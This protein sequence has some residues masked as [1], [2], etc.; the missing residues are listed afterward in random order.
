MT[1]LLLLLNIWNLVRPEMKTGD[2][3]KGGGRKY[4]F[5]QLRWD[6]RKVS[7]KS[8]PGHELWR[9]LQMINFKV[10]T[11]GF[12]C[13]VLGWKW[14]L[15]FPVPWTTAT[16]LW[17]GVGEFSSCCFCVASGKWK[18]ICERKFSWWDTKLWLHELVC[19]CVLWENAIKE[20]YFGRSFFRGRTFQL[21]AGS[22]SSQWTVN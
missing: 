15:S 6:R 4:N 12:S 20:M 17:A 3:R 1:S 18:I 11:L 5:S 21:T 2:V 19:D 8:G 16:F 13:R 14:E 10:E 22:S 7:D 9:K